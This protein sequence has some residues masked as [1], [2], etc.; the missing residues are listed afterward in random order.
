M[1]GLPAQ[2]RAARSDATAARHF[3]A[4]S[5]E[6]RWHSRQD[7]GVQ[8]RMTTVRLSSLH[9]LLVFNGEIATAKACVRHPMSMDVY[10]GCVRLIRDI[11]T[12]IV[13]YA[14]T[15]RTTMFI[16]PVNLISRFSSLS[17]APIFLANNY[18]DVSGEGNFK[19]S[20][21]IDGKADNWRIQNR[22]LLINKKERGNYA[23]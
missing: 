3:I 16:A 23:V 11:L 22:R 13:F 1:P 12:T 7:Y 4:S 10:T 8:I 19:I 17:R 14:D 20:Q 2:W 18:Q 9:S 5:C 15:Q 21:K 6:L